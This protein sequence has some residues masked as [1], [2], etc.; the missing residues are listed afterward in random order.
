VHLSLRSG[1]I[2]ASVTASFAALRLVH[3][4]FF[5]IEFLLTGGEHEF[6]SAFFADKSFVFVHCFYLALK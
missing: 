6:G 5:S 1:S 3:E 2:L 4:A